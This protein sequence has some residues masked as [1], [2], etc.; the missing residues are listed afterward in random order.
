MNESIYEIREI[1]TRYI[2]NQTSKKLNKIIN[3]LKLKNK[4]ILIIIIFLLL[5]LLLLFYK[6]KKLNSEIRIN[7]ESY[8][9][10]NLSKEIIK[11]YSN[12]YNAAKNEINKI[13]YNLPNYIKNNYNFI[14]K[15]GVGICCIGKNENLYAKEYVE[16]YLKLGIKKIIIYDNNDINGEKFEDI[17]EKY[18]KNNFVE[19]INIR[20]FQS[21]Q[22]P[23]YNL[24]Y[25]TFSN[26]FD[27]ISFLDFDEFITIQNN[28]NINEYIYDFKFHKCETILLNWVMYGDNDLEKYD[29]RS[30]IERFIK[31]HNKYNRGKSIVRTGIS[32]LI[33]ISTI[34]I[35]VNT[36]Y[37]CNS[38]GIR[39]FPNT[40][41]D[42][43]AP[44]NSEAF[45]KHFYTKTSEEFCFK[46]K[47]GDAHFHKEQ[48]DYINVRESRIK[49]FFGFNKITTEKIN[50]IEKC[51]GIN[52]N[53][54]RYKI[55]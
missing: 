1:K 51:S 4:F 24:C 16:Y 10:L 36:K 42:F 41:F 22:L 15:K 26:Q 13:P 37:F 27:F 3:N 52:L 2:D 5:F 49:L 20:G 7:C 8:N 21:V 47:R 17:L 40:Y 9:Q 14:E 31:P 19:I 45:I 25:K 32:N 38:N 29:N 30:M 11:I 46:I 55:K 28:M 43:Q 48:S 18:I 34:V 50:I 39:L 23:V 53:K 35:G 12:I 33:I 44:N 6:Y 54:Y